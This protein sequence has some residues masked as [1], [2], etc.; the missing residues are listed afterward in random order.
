[1]NS[2]V[3][4]F[5]WW[6]CSWTAAQ[7]IPLI[8]GTKICTAQTYPRQ[9]KISN[10]CNIAHEDVSIKPNHVSVRTILLLMEVGGITGPCETA[11][12]TLSKILLRFPSLITD[13]RRI[14]G[15]KI[16][17]RHGCN[18]MAMAK[19][20]LH[21]YLCIGAETSCLGRKLLEDLYHP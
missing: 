14:F 12:R 17:C 3:P 5:S 18:S 1:M 9:W 7:E 15:G 19:Q 6:V 8:Y 2:V 20:F 13:I 16:L 11:I 21:R 10:S 4:D